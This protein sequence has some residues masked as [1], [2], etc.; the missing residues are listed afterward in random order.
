MS[1][2]IIP[3]AFEAY[4]TQCELSGQSVVLDEILLANI[5]DLDPNAPVDR[6]KVECQ[7]QWIVHRQAPTQVGALN[8]NAIA[9]ALVLDTRVGDFAFNAIFLTN[10]ASGTIDGD[11]QGDGAQ[12]CLY[13]QPNRQQF[14]QDLGH[15]L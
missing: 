2:N 15:G 13:R 7:P 5:P 9:Y 1:Q 6:N 10:K 3:S 11:L 8:H 12:V 14:G 4:R